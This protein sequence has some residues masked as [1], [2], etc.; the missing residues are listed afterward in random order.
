MTGWLGK[1]FVA[2]VLVFLAAPLVVVA[3]VSVNQPKRLLFPPEGFS[4]R[5]Y[6][7]LFTKSDWAGSLTNSAIIAVLAGLLAVSVALPL[8]LYI[9]SRG[10]LLGRVLFGLGIAPFLLPPGH[11]RPRVHGVLDLGRPLRAHS[12][13]DHLACGVPGRAS[14]GHHLA[15]PRRHRPLVDRGCAHHGREPKNRVS[16]RCPSPGPPLRHLRFSLRRRPQ[17]E[18]VHHRL[19]G[20]RLLRRDPAD[21]DLPIPFVTVTR[22]SWHRPAVLFVLIAVVVFGAIAR[23]GDLPRLLGAHRSKDA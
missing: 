22:P 2:G 6:G 19:H 14:P 17:P 23:F 8:A 15:R 21:Q 4:L 11:L 10:G 5:W 9:W 12:R 13:D 3:G 7:E 18:R 16:D 20:R 1:A